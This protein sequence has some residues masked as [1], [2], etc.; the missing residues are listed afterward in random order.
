MKNVKLIYGPMFSG[1]SAHLIDLI[2]KDENNKNILVFKPD[3]D[4][5]TKNIY[6]RVGKTYEAININEAKDIFNYDLKDVDEIFIDEINFFNE[7]FVKHIKKICDMNIKVVLSGLD[8]DYRTK[9]FPYVKEMLDQVEDEN[10][11]FVQGKCF[12]CESKSLFTGRKV[13]GEFDKIDSE[14]IIPE[15]LGKSSVEYFSS[16]KKCHPLYE[17]V[18]SKNNKEK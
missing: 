15:T 4:K 6:S 2:E 9:Y 8:S 14:T 1:K 7:S 12:F 3:R 16:C 17:M 18:H 5:R 10:K 13:N 11:I